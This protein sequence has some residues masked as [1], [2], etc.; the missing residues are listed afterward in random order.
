[1][2]WFDVAVFFLANYFAHAATIKALPGESTIDLAFAVFLAIAF[3][4]PGVARGLGAIARHASFYV[5]SLRFE[6]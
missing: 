5:T 4:F 2:K 6:S 1:M 3:P